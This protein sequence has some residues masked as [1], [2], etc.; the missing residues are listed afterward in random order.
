MVCAIVHSAFLLRS[1]DFG[2]PN[3]RERC[4]LVGV[5]A[6]EADK[7]QLE[8]L[9][10]LVTEALPQVHHRVTLNDCALLAT[11]T[12]DREEREEWL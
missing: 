6:G 3:S 11:L 9:V 5:R 2:S 12:H 7:S 4:Y 1:K 10:K 8:G